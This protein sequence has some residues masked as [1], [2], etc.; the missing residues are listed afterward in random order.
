MIVGC[1]STELIKVFAE[2][3]I[4]PND[5]II[6]CS[7]TYDEYAFYCRLMGGLINRV[8][9]NE[10]RE[11]QLE[12]KSLFEQVNSSTKAVFLC[13]PNN[14]TSRYEDKKKILEIIEECESRN[15]L[16]F[17]DEA[18]ID[19]LKEGKNGSCVPEVQNHDNLFVSRSLTKIY[20]IPGI[21]VGYGVGGKE[22]IKYMNKAR[23]SWNVGVLDQIIASELIRNCDHYLK[24]TVEF[25][26]SEKRKLYTQVSRIPGYEPVR[27]DVN[28]LFIKIGRLGLSSTDFKS[29]VLDRGFLIRDCVS[30][31]ENF[32]D[33]IRIAVKN[34]S[35][36]TLLL[37]E[38]KKVSEERLSVVEANL[39]QL[40]KS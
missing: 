16:V 11:F 39:K 31:G 2:T 8:S 36:N 14:P 1:G 6:V 4:K 24:R 26:D 27:P 3:F 21:R 10:D 25:V 37:E 7:P 30:F 28:F 35:Q 32:S 19:F 33:Y 20:S 5:H 13:N 38:L 23:L 22:I 17:V 9:L 12:A 18:F 29:I 34:R 40:K 15:I